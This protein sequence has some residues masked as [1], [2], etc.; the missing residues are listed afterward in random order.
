MNEEN[1]TAAKP[2]W[3]CCSKED[4]E[5]NDESITCNKCNKLF[6]FRCLTIA[7]IDRD[8]EE[9]CKWKCSACTNI[10]PKQAKKDNTP[11]KNVSTTRGNKRLKLH[12][13]PELRSVT[14][15]EVRSIVEDVVQAQ[16]ATAIQEFKATIT[17]FLNSELKSIKKDLQELKESFTFHTKQ[18]D[19]MQAEH[20]TTKNTVKYLSTENEQLKNTIADLGEKLNYLEQQAR[21]NNVELQCLPEHKQ[22]NL[23][24]VTKQLGSVVGC[25]LKDTDILHATR[26]AK[27]NTSNP[28]PRS[29]VVQFVSSRIRDQLLAAVINYNKKHKDDKLNSSDLGMSGNRTPV[30]VVEHLSATNKSLHAA[31]RIKARERGYKYVWVRSGKIY[32]RRDDD[33]DHIHIKNIETLSKLV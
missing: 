29:V 32:V 4:E 25:D 26:I 3:S 18:F 6:H 20:V 9:Y 31:T 24:T 28:R 14:A 15:E 17:D 13:P 30:Y 2:S 19:D 1:M 21:S 10:P 5:G 22:E 7:S 27:L 11:M 33:T 8:S 16:Y 12:S 23:Y